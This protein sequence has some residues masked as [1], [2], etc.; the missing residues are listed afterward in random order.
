MLFSFESERSLDK[1]CLTY[2]FWHVSV[3][4]HG[5]ELL[6]EGWRAYL[7]VEG[8]AALIHDY[9]Q[10]AKGEEDHLELAGLKPPFDR[11]CH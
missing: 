6:H 1:E 7:L 2:F 11:F 10:Q 9:V 3:V 5:D 4:H 8:S